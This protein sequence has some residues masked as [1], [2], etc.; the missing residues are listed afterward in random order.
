MR[1]L[2]AITEIILPMAAGSRPSSDLGGGRALQK[3]AA[4]MGH[5]VVMG[6]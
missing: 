3:D 6:Y 1:G 4:D 5:I 2:E